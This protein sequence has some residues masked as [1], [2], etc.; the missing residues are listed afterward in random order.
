MVANLNT[1][2]H[3]HTDDGCTSD[4]RIVK[5][6]LRD[7]VKVIFG[8]DLKVY[9]DRLEEVVTDLYETHGG[10]YPVRLVGHSAGG[11]IGRLFLGNVSYQQKDYGARHCRK[12]C[13]LITLGAPHQSNENYPFGRFD[14]RL[15]LPP[16]V[17]LEKQSS[18]QFCNYFY[19]QGNEFE[20]VRV[21]CVA[22]DAIRGE[23]LL[24]PTLRNLDN[25]LAYQAYKA[26]C[27]DGSV[28]GDSVTPVCI[29]L[30]EKAHENIVL[31]GVW[32][33]TASR[34]GR[35]WYGDLD[36]LD[37]WAHHLVHPD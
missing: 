5:F 37:H 12:V 31:P 19:P 4:I 15:Y 14:E 16:S 9:L 20:G 33:G 26:V 21:V 17:T 10:D 6:S 30:L 11:W 25:V 27:G 28:T 18:L 7:W 32:H 3:Q 8:G 13:C 22:G 23:K 35:P 36:V 1:W 34:T 24:S 29:A 2:I